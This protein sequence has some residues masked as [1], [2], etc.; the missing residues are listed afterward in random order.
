VKSKDEHNAPLRID[1]KQAQLFLREEKPSRTAEL[2]FQCIIASLLLHIVVIFVTQMLTQDNS[3]PLPPERYMPLDVEMIAPEEILPPQEQVPNA[4]GPLRNVLA[5]QQ[6][7]YS[8]EVRD[9]RGMS[10]EEMRQAGANAAQEAA[11]AEMDRVLQQHSNAN[12]PARRQPENNPKSGQQGEHDWFKDPNKTSYNGAVTA[13][14][15]LQGR[16]ALYSPK[17]SYLCKISGTVVVQIA[18]DQLGKV[19][20]AKVQG[21]SST[22]DCLIEQSINYARKWTFSYKDAKARQDGTITFTFSAQ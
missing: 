2:V 18:V 21:G 16:D 3:I 19:I 6:S 8:N 7:T 20:D 10:S 9:Y 1:P 13:A 14:Y 17:P 5:N 12:M 15:S 22:N 11:Q 4:G